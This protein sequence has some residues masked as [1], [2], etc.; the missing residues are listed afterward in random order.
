MLY[1]MCTTQ[2]IH[3]QITRELAGKKESW[4][5]E[6]KLYAIMLWFFFL[7]SFFIQFLFK[8]QKMGQ[9]SRRWRARKSLQYS[10]NLHMNEALVFNPITCHMF[11]AI[12]TNINIPFEHAKRISEASD[13]GDYRFSWNFLY[14]YFTTTCP[15]FFTSQSQKQCTLFHMV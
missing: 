12:R 11:D 5:L 3:V 14:I 13:I 7:F 2:H 9:R 4:P 10:R 6:E 15:N 1:I 8:Q